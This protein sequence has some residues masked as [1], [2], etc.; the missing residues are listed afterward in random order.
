MDNEN[1][2]F[3]KGHVE[4]IVKIMTNRELIYKMLEDN[5]YDEF[6][7]VAM[8]VCDTM[9][10]RAFDNV[11]LFLKEFNTLS[12]KHKLYY[13]EQMIR[14]ENVFEGKLGDKHREQLSYINKDNLDKDVK[15]LVTVTFTW[16]NPDN[17][18]YINDS[19]SERMFISDSYIDDIEDNTVQKVINTVWKYCARHHE[20]KPP[21]KNDNFY[22]F[23][24]DC[25]CSCRITVESTPLLIEVSRNE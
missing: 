12:D 17:D 15:F 13:L 11:E 19:K 23:P 1:V 14:C 9:P 22:E 18:Q 2:L 25:W 8:K 20:N 10:I 21:Y 7:Q 24:Y 6:R 16:H 4:G 3:I 5:W